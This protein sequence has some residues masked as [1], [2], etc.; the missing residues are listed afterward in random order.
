MYEN[1]FKFQFDSWKTDEKA[2]KIMKE[3][4]SPRILPINF[5]AGKDIHN[6]E[7]YNPSVAARQFGF[8]QVPP[9]SSLSVKSNSE[10]LSIAL[11]LIIG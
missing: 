8:S 7:F 9:P 11:S 4:I 2:T 6:Y 10:K 1:P 3:I 5:T